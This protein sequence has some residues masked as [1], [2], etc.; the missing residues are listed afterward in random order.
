V[1]QNNAYTQYDA[2]A[3]YNAYSPN[4]LLY[5]KRDPNTVGPSEGGFQARG[6]QARGIQAGS[7]D[8][9]TRGSKSHADIFGA[10]ILVIETL[11]TVGIV[12]AVLDAAVLDAAVLDVSFEDMVLC[13]FLF[14]RHNR[15]VGKGGGG[16]SIFWGSETAADVT[17]A[18]GVLCAR[19]WAID[20]RC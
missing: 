6:I 19:V 3:Y 8:D 13:D 14:K 4:C 16:V 17:D 10:L 18:T 1:D 20:P 5:V 2:Q 11:R 7:D 15:D 9:S 12:S